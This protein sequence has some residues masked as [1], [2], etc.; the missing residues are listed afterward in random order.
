MMLQQQVCELHVFKGTYCT[1][2]TATRKLFT[3]QKATLCDE[4]ILIVEPVHIL[5]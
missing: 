3:K 1:I 4:A 5:Q 2:N